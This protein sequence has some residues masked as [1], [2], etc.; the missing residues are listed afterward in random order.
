MTKREPWIRRQSLLRI[1]D[2]F[3]G[4][5]IGADRRNL[6]KSNEIFRIHAKLSLQL[7]DTFLSLVHLQQ[8]E[9]IGKMHARIFRVLLHERRV[10]L[11]RLIEFS[12]CGKGF[13][14][15]YTEN[16]GAPRGVFSG[17]TVRLN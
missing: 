1:L 8:K 7:C 15:A 4:I 14:T 10:D 5:L 3:R 17:Y 12:R 11:V 9:S 16:D 13:G 2:S 6:Q